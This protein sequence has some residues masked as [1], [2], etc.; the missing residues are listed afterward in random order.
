MTLQRHTL[1]EQYLLILAD[2][3]EDS[4][5]KTNRTG[6]D[7]WEQPGVTLKADFAQGFP[8]LTTKKVMFK[9]VVSEL[10]WF[11]KGDTNTAYL[12][13][14]DNHIWDAWADER[15]D[16]GPVYGAQWRGFGKAYIDWIDSCSTTSLD[17]QYEPHER[18][19][20]WRGVDQLAEAIDKLKNKPDDRRIIV[21]AWNP[22]EIP[23]MRLP[24]CH[25]LFQFL[26]SDDKLHTIVYQRSADWF[27]GVP[28]NIASYALLTNL[29]G[30]ETDLQP[31]SLT[32]TF[33]SAHLYVNHEEQAREQLRRTPRPLPSVLMQPKP[34]DA[35]EPSD[36]TLVGYDPHPFIKA[37]VAV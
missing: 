29:V 17:F 14:H 3:L 1:E 24:P 7:T 2:L 28:F 23:D 8:L 4:P 12:H 10:L 15:G 25:L 18:Q 26:V 37:P 13:E 36:I 20:P 22:L 30:L 33:G 27:L 9:H 21:S 6:V 32:M 19:I 5:R 11:I 35:H 16:L 34:W 31:G